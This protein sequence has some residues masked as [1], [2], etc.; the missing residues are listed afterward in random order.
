MSASANDIPRE[1]LS[2]H[3]AERLSGKRL[4]GALFLTF[5]F[6]PGFFAATFEAQSR[7]HLSR[8]R[9]RARVPGLAEQPEHTRVN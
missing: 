7:A 8:H 9:R 5:E 6:D 4:L 1:V 3:F 2:E